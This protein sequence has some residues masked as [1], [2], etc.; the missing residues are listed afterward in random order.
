M[1][2][3]GLWRKVPGML[4]D[5]LGPLT[6][7]PAALPMLAPWLIR[8][9]AAGWTVPK[10]ERTAADLA[11]L[12]RDAPARH[13]RL[14]ARTGL[15]AL[16]RQDGLLYAY[17]DRAAFLQ[18]ALAWRLRRDNGVRWRELSEPELRRFEPS[19]AA[20]YRFGALVEA[21][22]HCLDPGAY[23]AGLCRAAVVG[24]A[25]LVKA[26]AVDFRR[27]AGRLAG[28]VLDQGEIACD[29]AVVAA[30][31]WSQALARKA[32]DR[33]PLASERGYHVVV[34]EPG[35]ALR[36][37]VMPSDGKMANTMTQAGLRA[38]GQVELAAIDAAPNWARA[39]VLLGHLKRSYPAL[40]RDLAADTLPRW[41]GHRPSTP[42]GRPVIGLSRALPGLHH[43]FGHGHIGLATGPITGRLL[44]DLISSRT[45]PV[46]VE[47]FAPERFAS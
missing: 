21:G 12:L 29:A 18:E 42:D 38:S 32:G 45:P 13:Q 27:A 30:G 8:F 9:L 33:I 5:P 23:V 28:V 43:G 10:V 41:R 22:A 14:A 46:A 4:L 31:V 40:P 6:L 20:H 11:T 24:G 17:P 3:P 44:A 34:P 1:A 15:A 47:P 16:I 25:A 37:P 2:L 19:L 35:F 36:A 26:R 39:D 7:R